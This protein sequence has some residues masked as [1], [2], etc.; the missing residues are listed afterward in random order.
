MWALPPSPRPTS[1][2]SFTSN[3]SSSP[4]RTES[5][6]P[7]FHAQLAPTEID[8]VDINKIFTSKFIDN[9]S[10]IV[11]GSKDGSLQVADLYTGKRFEIPTFARN[12]KSNIS[13]AERNN[14][15]CYEEGLLDSINKINLASGSMHKDS[16]Q[17]RG[18]MTPQR[19][20]PDSRHTSSAFSPYSHAD[21]LSAAN[22][23]RMSPVK[24]SASPVSFI[25]S[26]HDRLARA[27][28]VT[29]EP[30]STASGRNSPMLFM[31]PKLLENLSQSTDH[32]NVG[33]DVKPPA[34]DI[35]RISSGIYDI[36]INPSKTLLA[37]N[38]DTSRSAVIYDL[39]SFTPRAFLDF[40]ED[41]IFSMT[42]LS[43]RFIAT[44]SRDS[45][46]AIWD[47]HGASNMEMGPI[48]RQSSPA[49][50]NISML[51]PVCSK[52][53]GSKVRVIREDKRHQTFASLQVSG[54]VNLWD[55]NNLTPMRAVDIPN[56]REPVSMCQDDIHGLLAVGD[57]EYVTLI[58]MRTQQGVVKSFESLDDKWGVRSLAFN[59]H[60]LTI[61]GGYGKITFF[62]M[63]MQGFVNMPKLPSERPIM[64]RTRNIMQPEPTQKQELE[65][66]FGWLKQ[67]QTLLNNF[68]DRD[69]RHAVYTL[70]YDLTGTK[71]FTGG[72]DIYSELLVRRTDF[73]GIGGPL[74]IGLTG[75]YAA[76][77][78]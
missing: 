39:P 67:D 61:G 58:D 45:K 42:F 72:N 46:I 13:H 77:W 41:A 31:T 57:V 33:S 6:F 30:V 78:T 4:F 28:P 75:S 14:S 71:M 51:K 63:R 50:H 59:R 5:P 55:V 16:R 37:A 53:T 60:I 49:L 20:R 22:R 56:A 25:A 40:H 1:I 38:D 27:S 44:A 74:Q 29:F 32:C 54:Q 69:I 66:G 24:G 62:D 3:R 34:E 47:L 65:T 70:E 23:S 10:K 11:L 18:S 17:R 15:P 7:A 35:S 52:A 21:T 48:V 2:L 73:D 68:G 8:T 43:D 76:L 9:D 26:I 19:V 64:S 36:A 12:R